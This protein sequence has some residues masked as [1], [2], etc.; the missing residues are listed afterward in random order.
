MKLLRRLK[1][2]LSCLLAVLLVGGAA[3]PSPAV[4]QCR[5]SSRVV[6]TAFAPPPSAMPCLM[7]RPMASMPCCHPKAP[8]HLQTGQTVSSAPCH[9]T[10]IS[11]AAAAALGPTETHTHLRSSLASQQTA[12]F[13]LP[14]FAVSAPVMLSNR[15]RPP[16]TLGSPASAPEHSPSL[17]APPTA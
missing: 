8:G 17:R 6:S 10:L 2:A 14:V 7:D 13:P 11:L 3:L 4:W 5:Y 12:L 15:Q 9:P 1:L 16:P